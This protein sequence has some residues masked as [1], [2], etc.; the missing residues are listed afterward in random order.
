MA[1]SSNE[2][3]ITFHVVGDT[4]ELTWAGEFT[5]KKRLSHRDHLTKDGVR[6]E[7]LGGQPGTPTERALTTAMIL[8]ELRVRL[9]KWPA[10]WDACNKGLDLEDDNVLGVLWDEVNKVE[11][12]AVEAKKKKAE[13]V[14]EELRAEAVKKK[15]DEA[16]LEAAAAAAAAPQP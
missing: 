6:R 1:T 8:S 7:L 15:A 16:A 11:G 13:K 9:L 10:W 5:A 3:S 12:E 2:A 14:Q 4:T